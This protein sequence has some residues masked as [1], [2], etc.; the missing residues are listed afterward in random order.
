MRCRGFLKELL[1]TKKL[2]ASGL[3]IGALSCGTQQISY[4]EYARSMG[5]TQPP[6]EDYIPEL[7]LAAT[8]GVI[9]IKDNTIF[10]TSTASGSQLSDAEK[11]DIKAGQEV[12][13][14]SVAG[15]KDG[16]FQVTLDKAPKGCKFKSGFLYEGHVTVAFSKAFS[17]TAATDTKLKAKAVDA[18]GLTAAEMCEIKKGSKIHLEGPAQDAEGHHS[19]ITVQVGELTTCSF[20]TGFVLL[21][22]F[23]NGNSQNADHDFAKVMKHILIWE[24]GCSDHPND[25]GGRTYKGITAERGRMNGW[26]KD[27]CTMSHDMI[28]DIYRK[29]YWNKRAVK[30]SWPLNL[31][32]MNTEVNSGGGRAEKFIVRMKTEKKEG[33]VQ[34]KAGWFVDQQSEFYRIIANNNPSLRVFLKGWLNRSAHMQDVISGR[35]SLVEDEMYVVPEHTAKA[36][37]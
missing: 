25:P 13:F 17:L 23:E 16:H 29:D 36:F 31:A 32:V 24:G 8:Q 3:C 33:S 12:V 30:Y 27:I 2:L 14:S 34:E 19:K 10:K 37:E 4:N 6:E 9:R 21:Q 18:S 7:G 11:C 26:T 35:R 20:R 15:K 5:S 28:L 1:V 22:D